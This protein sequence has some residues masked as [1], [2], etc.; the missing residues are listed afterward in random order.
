M[1]LNVINDNEVRFMEP[2]TCDD[3]FLVHVSQ[4]AHAQKLVPR[5]N[6][7]EPGYEATCAGFSC[8]WQ[9][10]T[11]FDYHIFQT[12]LPAASTSYTVQ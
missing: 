3:L 6:V 2:I 12:S 7:E 1:V 9:S 8:V 5:L 11:G 4:N 10:H